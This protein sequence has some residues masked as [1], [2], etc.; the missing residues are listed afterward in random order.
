MIFLLACLA[1]LGACM[2]YSDYLGRNIS[3]P[4]CAAPYSLN[5]TKCLFKRINATKVQNFSAKLDDGSYSGLIVTLNDSTSVALT[6]RADLSEPYSLESWNKSFLPLEKWK[7]E[8]NVSTFLAKGFEELWQKKKMRERFQEI[9]NESRN[10]EVL[11]TGHYLGGAL[12][13]LVAYDIVKGRLAMKDN[14]TVITL[15]QMMVGDENFTRAYEEEVAYSFRVVRRLDLIP[16]VPGEEKG[17]AFN[18]REVFYNKIGMQ[19]NGTTG[20]RICNHNN[21]SSEQYRPLNS[22]ENDVYF[23]KNITMYG[24][25]C[26]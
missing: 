2:N 26:K 4:L 8:G 12:A 17:Y 25:K 5:A 3:L 21:C 23:K 15:G 9:M 14:V 19:M 20:F 18:G 1:T 10:R 16:H 7:Y 13:A 22:E 6:F 11:V 24:M